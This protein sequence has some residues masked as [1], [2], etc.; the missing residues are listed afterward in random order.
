MEY[1]DK[2]AL[3]LMFDEKSPTMKAWDIVNSLHVTEEEVSELT[4]T[5][6]NLLV[7]ASYNT[8]LKD[9]FFV[10]MYNERSISYPVIYEIL[11]RRAG[12]IPSLREQILS[13]HPPYYLH[14]FL[15]SNNANNQ[16]RRLV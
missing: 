10:R 5:Y 11:K 7:A 3:I 12:I 14:Q 15:A 2:K 4:L 13:S 8:A 6:P 1:L 9:E 16:Y